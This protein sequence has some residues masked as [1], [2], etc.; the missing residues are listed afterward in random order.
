MIVR[1]SRVH[2]RSEHPR[3]AS[4]VPA[5]RALDAGDSVMSQHDPEKRHRR[6]DM[7]D[8]LKIIPTAAVLGA[9]IAGVDLSRPLHDA[10]FTASE[11]A[12]DEYCVSY[13][14]GQC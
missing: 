7:P 1:L 9:E 2:D 10:T 4:R 14:R 13:F 5:R 3:Y 8:G 12:Y 6:D 11:L